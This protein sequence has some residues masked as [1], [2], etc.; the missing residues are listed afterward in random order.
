M[1]R[2]VNKL[3]ALALPIPSLLDNTKIKSRVESGKLDLT[4][5]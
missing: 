5:S 2:F 3:C 4:V 1:V